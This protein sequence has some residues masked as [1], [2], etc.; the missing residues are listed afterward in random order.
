[1]VPIYGA[2]FAKL[3]SAR[4][5]INRAGG[6][7]FRPTHDRCAHTKGE[8]GRQSCSGGQTATGNAARERAVGPPPPLRTLSRRWAHFITEVYELDP[9]LCDRDTARCG[10]FPSMIGRRPSK[11]F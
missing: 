7:S 10:P 9:L 5:H 1:M 11:R 8:D 2:A 4:T 3:S 6:T